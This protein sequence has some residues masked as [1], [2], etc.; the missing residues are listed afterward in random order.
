MRR[1]SKVRFAVAQ[2]HVVE[3]AYKLDRKIVILKIFLGFI[4]NNRYKVINFKTV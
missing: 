3:R 2:T 1:V 4:F